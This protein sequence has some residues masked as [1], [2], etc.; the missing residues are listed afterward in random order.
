M[1]DRGTLTSQNA[2]TEVYLSANQ[3]QSLVNGLSRST[4]ILDAE[5]E[6]AILEDVIQMC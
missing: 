4:K 5:Y 6:P 2:L 3:P 1:K